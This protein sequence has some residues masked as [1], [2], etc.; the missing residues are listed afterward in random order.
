VIHGHGQVKDGQ[1]LDFRLP[2]NI[3]LAVADQLKREG[4]YNQLGDFWVYGLLTSKKS[5]LA[6]LQI[7]RR[8]FEQKDAGLHD[9]GLLFLEWW[10]QEHPDRT[11]IV[12]IKG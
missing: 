11:N 6:I 5:N 3:R 12:F 4:E 8:G 10:K 1:Y 9:A 7:A 2:Q